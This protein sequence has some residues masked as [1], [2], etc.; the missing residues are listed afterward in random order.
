MKKLFSIIYI[1]LIGLFSSC[2]LILDVTLDVLTKATITFDG[3]GNTAGY[4][5]NQYIE[6]TNGDYLDSCTYTK[7]GYKFI[8]W[9]KNNKYPMPSLDYEDK[10][11]IKPTKS[12]T[13][14]AIWYPTSNGDS[15]YTTIPS[16]KEFHG[17]Q[18]NSS[19][20]KSYINFTATLRGESDH[21][22]VYVKNGHENN[23]APVEIAYLTEN[24]DKH[25]DN[26]IDIY[27]THT[28]IDNNN[29]VIALL[30]DVNKTISYGSG[31][32]GGFFN[33]A[34]L[35]DTQHSNNAEVLHIES[36]VDIEGIFPTIIHEFQHLINCNMNYI[37]QPV[38][39]QRYSDVW[40]NEGL[41]ESTDIYLKKA[42]PSGR[43]YGYN[44][45]KNTTNYFYT[46]D[47][48]IDDYNTV[49][50]FMYW[51]YL[52]SE[53][54]TDI[55]KKIAQPTTRYGDYRDLLSALPNSGTLNHSS[56]ETLFS[57]WLFENEKGTY[58]NGKYKDSGDR[59]AKNFTNTTIA[60]RKNKKTG[61]ISLAPGD[62][63]ITSSK[64]T[65]QNDNIHRTYSGNTYITLNKDK[66]VEGR[67]KI[68]VTVA[69]PVSTIMLSRQG[70][71][72]QNEIPPP[73]YNIIQIEQV[74]F[75]GE[76][77]Q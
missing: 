3:N 52:K 47:G 54:T 68:T 17:I 61:N 70:T 40:L 49:S 16:K 4:M 50:L 51:L 45:T 18:Y 32:V 38:G 66:D 77:T 39:S 62:A 30:Y 24:F 33:S 29:K 13:L 63:V 57:A 69:P 76:N 22:K 14:Y 28:D 60:S 36:S 20:T 23:V 6:I 65:I 12:M 35:F 1:C 41:S 10:E 55:F 46:W 42:M 58:K 34:D 74:P 37:S 43:L 31:Y 8:G 15:G 25:Y 19:G 2:D 44:T 64:T 56:L 67:N 21:L 59:T 7:K 9:T 71:E 27:G 48:V 75:Y 72:P 11:F 5:S 53:E 26:M 73:K